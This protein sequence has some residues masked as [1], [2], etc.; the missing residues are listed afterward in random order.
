MIAL[1][2]DPDRRPSEA[3]IRRSLQALDP[4]RLTAAIDAWLATQLAPG[5]R[6]AKERSRSTARLGAAHEPP[7]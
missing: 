1:G 4:D 2:I 7:T 5:R 3:M 6:A